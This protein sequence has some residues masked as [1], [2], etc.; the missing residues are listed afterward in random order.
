MKETKGGARQPTQMKV[1]E[2]GVSVGGASVGGVS[3]IGVSVGGVSVGRVSVIGV[4]VGGVRLS[5][6]GRSQCS[7]SSPSLTHINNDNISLYLLVWVSSPLD[8]PHHEEATAG[9]HC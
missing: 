5:Q 6:C 4:S 7:P 1:R 9:T 2:G 8:G 3:V